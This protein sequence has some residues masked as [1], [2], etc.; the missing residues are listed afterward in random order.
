MLKHIPDTQRYKLDFAELEPKETN[1]FELTVPEEFD[2]RLQELETVKDKWRDYS[3]LLD[4]ERIHVLSNT[5]SLIDQYN[6]QIQQRT[7]LATIIIRFFIQ[8][9]L[10][11]RLWRK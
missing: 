8:S 9:T 3:K 4:Q 7:R 10:W 5:Q 1:D 2:K 11:R 6:Q